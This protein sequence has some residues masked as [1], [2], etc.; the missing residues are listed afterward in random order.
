MTGAPETAQRVRFETSGGPMAFTDVGTGPAVLLLHGIP[1]WS[2]QWRHFTPALA[3][4]S[5]VIVPD[6]IGAGASAKPNDRPL[7]PVAQVGYLRELLEHLG[8][9]RLAVVGHGTGGAVAQLLALDHLGVAAMVLLN[10]DPVDD[11]RPAIPIEP[12]DPASSVRATI[13]AVLEMGARQRSRITDDLIDAYADPYLDDPAALAR[14]AGI[15]GGEDVT[16]RRDELRRIEVP[17]LILW[18]EEDPLA[19]LEEA[20]RLNEAIASSTLGVLPG[21]GHF[22][23]DEAAETLAPMV[24]EYLRAMYLRAPHGHADAAKEG[25]VMLQ[26]ERRPPWVDLAEDEADDWFVED[27][28]EEETSP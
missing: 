26:L 17:V 18:G 14:A 20:D 13:R 9:D 24:A 5:R 12:V 4:R 6:L 8:I 19:S 10:P 3:A 25:V 11:P 1:F 2:V 21:C 7:H 22:L 15:A 23:P 16:S 27:D 28:E